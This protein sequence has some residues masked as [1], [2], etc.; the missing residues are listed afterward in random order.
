M[1]FY[2]GFPPTYIIIVC[3]DDPKFGIELDHPL[4]YV[5][6]IIEMSDGPFLPDVYNLEIVSGRNPRRHNFH[7]LG[8]VLK[9]LNISEAELRKK[10]YGIKAVELTVADIKIRLKNGF[11]YGHSLPRSIRNLPSDAKVKLV[12]LC[13]QLRSLFDIDVENMDD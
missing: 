1:V 12:P 10:C 8:D 11:M 2:V 4:F 9:A 7:L 13:T 6:P 5:S 3:V